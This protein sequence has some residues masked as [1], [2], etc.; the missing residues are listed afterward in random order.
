MKPHQD[1]RSAAVS[2]TSLRAAILIVAFALI[3]SDMI[4]RCVMSGE[5][6]NLPSDLRL[7]CG[8]LRVSIDAVL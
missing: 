5:A 4:A 1:G 8:P 7:L 3:R 2:D 6:V